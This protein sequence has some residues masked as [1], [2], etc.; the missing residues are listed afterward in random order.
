MDQRSRP[1]VQRE[2]AGGRG[3][4]L[5]GRLE[6]GGPLGRI[7]LAVAR[8][9]QL[10]RLVAAIAR[11]VAGALAAV[12]VGPVAR[13]A[14]RDVR[15]LRDV[16]VA[17][18]DSGRP[19]HDVGRERLLVQLDADRLQLGLRDRLARRPHGVARRP[20]P[21]EDRRQSRALPDGG[22]ARIDRARPARAVLLQEGE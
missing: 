20:R 9:H 19:E 18:R 14:C 15:V 11:V 8:L 16:E 10:V 1:L 12:Q 2:H 5:V 13:I 21:V 22:V 3:H 7:E 17:G 4:E 6:V